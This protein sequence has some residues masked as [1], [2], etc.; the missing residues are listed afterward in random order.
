MVNSAY[1]FSFYFFSSTILHIHNFETTNVFYWKNAQIAEKAMILMILP[2]C[3]SLF[4]SWWR[5]YLLFLAGSLPEF[6]NS[7]LVVPYLSILALWWY[8]FKTAAAPLIKNFLAGLASFANYFKIP[9]IFKAL[10]DLYL[11]EFDNFPI[12]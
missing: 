9:E 11:T 3:G 7:V 8:L 1:N 6:S 12:R 5:R 2:G 10:E 4:F